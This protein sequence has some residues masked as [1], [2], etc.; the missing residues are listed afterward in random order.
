VLSYTFVFM[1]GGRDNARR[2]VQVAADERWTTLVDRC[3]E[4]NDWANAKP[5]RQV[6][7]W[8]PGIATTFVCQATI[9]SIARRFAPEVMAAA[10]KDEYWTDP[11]AN[12]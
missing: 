11:W 9:D 5:G 4:A 3:S 2:V 1:V 7:L 12:I 6:K 10:Q 8:G